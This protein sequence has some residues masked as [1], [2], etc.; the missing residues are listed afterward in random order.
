M[1]KPSSRKSRRITPWDG[2]AN[3][4]ATQAFLKQ[5]Y[6]AHY[7]ERHQAVE[8]SGEADMINS[9]VP[10]ECPFCGSEEFRKRGLSQSGIQRYLCVCGKAF[11]PTTGTIFDDRKISISEWS[12]A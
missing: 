2:D 5:Y 11:P 1:A 3:L 9:Y 4:T 7:V 10:T 6:D 8:E 12:T